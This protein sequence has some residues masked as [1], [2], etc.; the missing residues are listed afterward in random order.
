V[1][2]NY[3]VVGDGFR[4]ANGNQNFVTLFHDACLGCKQKR[5]IYLYLKVNAYLSF[6]QFQNAIY[7][8]Y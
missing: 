2:W 8:V 1:L 3:V 4:D 6:K 7:K 5:H